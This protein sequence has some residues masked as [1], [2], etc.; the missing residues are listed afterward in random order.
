[1]RGQKLQ[2]QT[3]ILA[4]ARCHPLPAQTTVKGSHASSLNRVDEGENLM[5]GFFFLTLS[6]MGL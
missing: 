2:A 1:M 3:D 5:K 4:H 6:G